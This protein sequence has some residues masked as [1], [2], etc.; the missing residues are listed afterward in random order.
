MALNTRTHPQQLILVIGATGAQGSAVINKLLA[1]CSDG[2]PSPYA[3]RAMTRDLG[4]RRAKE[5]A[6]RGIECVQG[7]FDD[8]PSVAAALEGA[9]GAWVNTDGFTVG[10]EKEVWAGIRIF[11]IAKQVGTL[12]HYIWSSL[13][14]ALKE[15][16]YDCKYRCEHYDGKG[17][18]ADWIKSQSNEVDEDGMTWSIVTSGPYMDMLFNM[19]FGPLKRRADGTVVFATPIGD[20]HIPMIALSDLGFFARYT[21]DNRAYTA[22]KE[23]KIASDWVGWEYLTETFRKVT[24]QKTEIIYQTLDEWFDNFEGVNKPIANER[25][26]GD[27]STTWRTNFAGWWALWRDD[28]IRRDFAWIRKINPEGHTLESWMRENAYTGELQRDNVLKNSEDGKTISPRR[29]RILQL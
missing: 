8:F 28:I 16:H 9:Y 29:D 22:G 18:V 19:M 6:S 12:K 2:S 21:F 5:F 10:E 13:D 27:G 14:Y 25:R 11:E 26:E 4:S 17:R 24:G 20:G 1:P 3:V 15:G 7:A 23:L